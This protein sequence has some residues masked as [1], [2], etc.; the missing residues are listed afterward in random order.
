MSTFWTLFVA[1]MIIV[2]GIVV[3]LAPCCASSCEQR[4]C[5]ADLGP[6][7]ESPPADAFVDTVIL[8]AVDF[9]PGG[10][11]SYG[12]GHDV[13]DEIYGRVLRIPPYV[14]N[15]LRTTGRGQ[16]G[17]SDEIPVPRW[18]QEDRDKNICPA[19]VMLDA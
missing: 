19:M 6:V 2:A 16:L 8:A 1:A 9:G 14:E 5:D 17:K 7:V 18:P 10:V 15:W 4:A 12:T 3:I 11:D 13:Y